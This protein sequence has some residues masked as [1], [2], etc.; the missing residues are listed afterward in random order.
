M[1]ISPVCRLE[2][3]DTADWKSALQGAQNSELDAALGNGTFSRCASRPRSR[4]GQEADSVNRT[5]GPV[6]FH[7][8][9]RDLDGYGGGNGTFS[10]CASRPRSRRGQEPDSVNRT[11]GPLVFHF[12]SRDLDGYGGRNGQGGIKL[13]PAQ[14]RSADFQSAVSQVSNLRTAEKASL[15][16]ISPVCRLE[17]GGT[18]GRKSGRIG[19]GAGD[20]APAPSHTT[21]RAVF[22][23][24]RLNAA[25]IYM[26][27]ARS[28]GT[29][30]PR[31]RRS[32]LFKA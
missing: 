30:N 19:S 29:R 10:R 15:M 20:C 26:G 28:E 9:S 17:V 12:P 22:R 4:R 23:I 13:R 32:P 2:V 21:G 8:P 16:G 7:F 11:P 3:G 24:R 14:L 1:G 27:A 6:V 31:R 18:A 25:T 5:L